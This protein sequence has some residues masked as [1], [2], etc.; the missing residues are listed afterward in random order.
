MATRE[1]I[2]PEDSILQNF[3][4]YHKMVAEKSVIQLNIHV[5]YQQTLAL[6][7]L[8]HPIQ[9]PTILGILGPMELE[10][11]NLIKARLLIREKVLPDCKISAKPSTSGLRRTEI[12]LLISLPHHGAGSVSHRASTTLL[13]FMLSE[14]VARFQKV[15]MP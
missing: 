13:L 11:A 1:K 14:K 2:A 7:D 6:E 15:E 5:V 9:G 8:P 12:R 3:V 4:K 10:N